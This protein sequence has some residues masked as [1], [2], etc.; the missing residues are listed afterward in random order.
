M[1]DVIVSMVIVVIAAV[2]RNPCRRGKQT[3]DEGDE[4][5]KKPMTTKRFVYTMAILF[6]LFNIFYGGIEVSR[7]MHPKMGINGAI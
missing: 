2:G 3:K 1:Y 7:F 4:D 5:G 6:F